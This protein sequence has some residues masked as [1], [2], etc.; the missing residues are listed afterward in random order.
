MEL[1]SLIWPGNFIISIVAANENTTFAITD[2]KLYVPVVTLSTENNSKLLQQLKSGFKLT[3]NLNKYPPKTE[4]L[5]VPN[6]YLDYL[7]EPSFQGL[8][9][10]LFLPCNAF[11]NRTGHSRYYLP[12]EKVEDYNVMMH[13]RK[14]F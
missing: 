3:V 2:T 9:R 11:G 6:P 1:I 13:R 7:I 8:N 14:I 5:N 4:T 12:T 10:L